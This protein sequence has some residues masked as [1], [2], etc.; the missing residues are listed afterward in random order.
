MKY[1]YP[2]IFRPAEKGMYE[3]WFPDLD[4]CF[5]SGENLADAIL[6]ASDALNLTLWEME[7]SKELLP[8]PSA[9]N[10]ISKQEGDIV[11][12]IAADTLAYRKK[13]DK[14]AVKKTLS[15]P[16]WMDCMALERNINF[17]NVLQKALLREFGME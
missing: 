17:S 9:L 1:S 3:V 11:N 10:E 12:L 6:Q 14:R 13:Y 2:A 5:T 4:N 16:R 7:E 8:K 15:I